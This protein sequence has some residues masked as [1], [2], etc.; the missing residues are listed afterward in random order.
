MR[1]VGANNAVSWETFWNDD[2]LSLS[3]EIGY[4]AAESWNCEAFKTELTGLVLQGSGSCTH[5]ATLPVYHGAGEIQYDW[6]KLGARLPAALRAWFSP[7]GRGQ[8]PFRLQ[9][10]PWNVMANQQS[11]GRAKRLLSGPEP[12][13][14][15]F[16]SLPV[17]C[18]YGSA[19]TRSRS[20]P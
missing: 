6:Q 15:A 20:D 12:L 13:W 17:S 14:Q 7:E 3:A 9:D 5:A 2:R 8:R 11:T 1:T 19:R 10:R 4:A 16:S 18:R